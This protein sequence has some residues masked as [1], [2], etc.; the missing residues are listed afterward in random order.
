MLRDPGFVRWLAGGLDLWQTGSGVFSTL[1]LLCHSCH[2]LQVMALVTL[3]ERFR[4]GQRLRGEGPTVFELYGKWR[5][6]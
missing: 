5:F 6:C 4:I 3:I 1:A 2:S